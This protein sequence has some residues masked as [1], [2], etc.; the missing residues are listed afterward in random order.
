MQKKISQKID[1][2]ETFNKIFLYFSIFKC[3]Q[4]RPTGKRDTIHGK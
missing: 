3:T 1:D 2:F 4:V